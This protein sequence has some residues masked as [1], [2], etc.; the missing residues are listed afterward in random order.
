MNKIHRICSSDCRNE[1]LQYYDWWK[2]SI[3][4][5]SKND[6]RTDGDIQNIATGQ[7]DECTIGC[8]QNYHYFKE[9]Y[10]MM[11]KDLSKQQ[12][13]NTDPKLMQK[14]NFTRNLDQPGITTMSHI[15][16][17]VTKKKNI[18]I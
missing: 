3:W 18:Y 13:L 14:I 12:A 9:K 11:T 1:R 10:K 6:L 15:L 7:G 5:T 4:S 17:E 16:Q 8:L 2:K